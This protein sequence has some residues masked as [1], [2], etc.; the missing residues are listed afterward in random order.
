[1]KTL[2]HFGLLCALTAIPLATPVN[3]ADLPPATRTISVVGT[4]TQEVV[5]THASISFGVVGEAADVQTAKQSHDVTMKRLMTIFHDL[6]IS[7]SQVRTNTFSISP[8]YTTNPNNNE[9][10]ISGYRVTNT[11]TVTTADIN[12]LT[13]V[14]DKAVTV[15]ANVV[16]NIRF[17]VNNSTQ[18]ENTLISAAVR[19]GK[20]K[21]ELIAKAAGAKV[22]GLLQAEVYDNGWGRVKS[23]SLYATD[24]AG[25]AIASGTQEV[26]VRINLVFAVMQ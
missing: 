7:A 12:Q 23:A 11:L 3:A 9:S 20:R 24:Q 8:I 1:M 21:A 26:S 10:R 14:L 13:A 17:S 18:L 19:D 6:G 25:T 4:A 16:D 22:G 15:G 2:R 5:P